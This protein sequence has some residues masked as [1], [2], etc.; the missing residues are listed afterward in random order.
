MK[1]QRISEINSQFSL[2]P[3]QDFE[4]FKSRFY[5]SDLG[6]IHSA[7]P[8]DDMIKAFKLKENHKGR[9]LLFPPQ[10]RLA[11]IPNSAPL[12]SLFLVSRKVQLFF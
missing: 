2:F 10:D 3:A 11:L 5:K 7:I 6:K 1:V 12:G 4:L 8:W 9:N